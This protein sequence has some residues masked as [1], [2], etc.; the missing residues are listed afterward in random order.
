M[1][2]KLVAW[3]KLPHKANSKGHK[4]DVLRSITPGSE[5]V[6]S[7]A[8]LIEARPASTASKTRPC[9]SVMLLMRTI[10]RGLD[11]KLSI[12]VELLQQSGGASRNWC[13]VR[14]P[15]VRLVEILR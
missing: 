3:I 14:N 8:A 11:A 10:L 9:R 4:A 1:S 5:P 6:G 12:Y 2:I 7:S 15:H 13:M